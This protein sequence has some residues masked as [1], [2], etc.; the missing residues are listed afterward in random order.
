MPA[1]QPLHRHFNKTLNPIYLCP[2][3]HTKSGVTKAGLNWGT[4]QITLA[5]AT[6]AEDHFVN[7]DRMIPYIPWARQPFSMWKLVKHGPQRISRHHQSSI[8]S[9]SSPDFPQWWC[10]TVNCKL[11]Q[12]LSSPLS[13]CLLATVLLPTKG[14]LESSVY[15]EKSLWRG[16]NHV[17]LHIQRVQG[18][19]RPKVWSERVLNLGGTNLTC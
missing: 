2:T 13:C 19:T 16:F 4:A 6:S 3:W 11:K 8:V 12:T 14:N 9:A 1:P 5:L 17:F 7:S 15:I 18:K 10:V